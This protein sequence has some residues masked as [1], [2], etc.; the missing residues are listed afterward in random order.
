M[1]MNSCNERSGV[2]TFYGTVFD[3]T[4]QNGQNV[5]NNT[6][7]SGAIVTASGYATTGGSAVT[8][9]DGTYELPINITFDTGVDVSIRITA[10]SHGGGY[11]MDEIEVEEISIFPNFL[12]SKI[13]RDFSIYN[14]DLH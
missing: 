13:K 7:M 5:G 8:G 1:L 11:Q 3:C 9:Y 4:V 6:P 14:Y 2:I 10:I 12:G